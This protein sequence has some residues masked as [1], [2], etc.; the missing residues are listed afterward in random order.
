VNTNETSGSIEDRKFLDKMSDHQ[1][2]KNVS[3]FWNQLQREVVIEIHLD[4]N[5]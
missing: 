3:A 2:L 5:K 1:F 4:G